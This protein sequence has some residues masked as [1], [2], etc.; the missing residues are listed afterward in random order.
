MADDGLEV[1]M[2]ARKALVQMRHDLAKAIAA[3]SK[4]EDAESAVERIAEVQQA[5]E[6]ID[7]A[8]EELEQADDDE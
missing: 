3:G 6:V 2:D 7:I 5:I 4:N 8:I 1:L